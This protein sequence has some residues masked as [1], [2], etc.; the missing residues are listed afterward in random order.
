MLRLKLLALIYNRGGFRDLQVDDELVCLLSQAITSCIRHDY[1]PSELEWIGR[2]ESSRR[3]LEGSDERIIQSTE[4]YLDT[5]IDVEDEGKTEKKSNLAADSTQKWGG[6]LLFNLVRTLKPQVV[7][8]LGTLFGI[9]CA[10]MA[11]SCKITGSGKVISV[12]KSR[13]RLEVARRNIQGLGL[14]DQVLIKNTSFEETLSQIKEDDCRIDLAFIDGHKDGRAL[15]S[16]YRQIRS[17]A[18][19]RAVIVIDDIRFS[20]EMNDAWNKICEM[21]SGNTVI[22]LDRMG[23]V[24]LS[25]RGTEGIKAKIIPV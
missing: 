18:S 9:S 3:E 14:E 21:E 4:K 20:K 8:E 19:T 7:I 25:G 22:D 17:M 13:P 11:A 2:I 23:L 16:Y 12:D 24:G 10:Y 6:L 5:F 1:C 15:L